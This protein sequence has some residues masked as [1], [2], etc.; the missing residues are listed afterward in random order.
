MSSKL[1]VLFILLTASIVENCWLKTNSEC[2]S[3]CDA[4][5]RNPDNS[6]VEAVV[7]DGDVADFGCL[8]GLANIK[9]SVQIASRAA[10]KNSQ[11]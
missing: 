1:P 11:T 5:L 2:K 10:W 9:V 3:L 6:Y 7:L 8:S 4:D